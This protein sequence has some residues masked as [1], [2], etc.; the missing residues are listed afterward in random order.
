MQLCIKAHVA[1]I[2]VDYSLSPEHQ[3]PVALE[4]CYNA[5]QW[6]VANAEAIKVNA[7]QIAVGGDSAGGNLSTTLSREYPYL[8]GKS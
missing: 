1:V 3:F 7:D 5:L 4:D 8:E 2:F 6:V